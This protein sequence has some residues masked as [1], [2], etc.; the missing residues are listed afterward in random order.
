MLGGG[1]THTYSFLSDSL[2]P[3]GLEP[4]RFLCPWN[5]PGKSIGG[6]PFPSPGDLPNPGIEPK[7]LAPPALA[8]DTFITAP[9]GKPT[10]GPTLW[11]ILFF[12]PWR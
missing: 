7:S 2:Q 3:H 6:L 11:Q 12:S 10:K 1:R 4:S 9:P 5:F 8:G